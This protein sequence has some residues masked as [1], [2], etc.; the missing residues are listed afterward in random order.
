MLTLIEAFCI[1]LGY[2]LPMPLIA[3]W[4]KHVYIDK[5]PKPYDRGWGDDRGVVSGIA[6]ALWPTLF[7]LVPLVFVVSRLRRFLHPVAVWKYVYSAVLTRLEGPE[8]DSYASVMGHICEFS[9]NRAGSLVCCH[10][11]P[12]SF[13]PTRLPD[14]F[15]A[16]GR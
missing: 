5:A 4:L 16:R 15:A 3:A 6:V 14:P 12:D 11:E 2:C 9:R 1:L 10:C 13:A 7:V 8:T